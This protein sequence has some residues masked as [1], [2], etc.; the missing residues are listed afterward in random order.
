MSPAQKH[1]F[2]KRCSVVFPCVGTAISQQ[3]DDAAIENGPF[4]LNGSMHRDDAVPKSK[5]HHLA[6]SLMR[7]GLRP[8]PLPMYPNGFM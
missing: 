6:K 8:G 5:P 4:D 3:I 1:E 2:A 7:F